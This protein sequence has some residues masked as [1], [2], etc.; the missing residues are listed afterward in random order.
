M[1]PDAAV[2]CLASLS[3]LCP[4][5]YCIT[6]RWP[7][8]AAQFGDVPPTFVTSLLASCSH[9]YYTTGRWLSCAAKCND[10]LA[11]LPFNN[12]CK[13]FQ[14]TA[15]SASLSTHIFTSTF[16]YLEYLIT[17]TSSGITVWCKGEES[18]KFC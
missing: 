7:W 4:H 18:S 3:A 12:F 17:S 16:Y 5:R 11:P 15:F 1:L 9:S 2:S 13:W 8:N 14:S 6:A 10:L